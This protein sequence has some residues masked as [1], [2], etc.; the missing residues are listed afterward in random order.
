MQPT[1]KTPSKPRR[2]A[3]LGDFFGAA[4]AAPKLAPGETPI[5][6]YQHEH[7]PVVNRK[8]EIMLKKLNA[9]ES[10]RLCHDGDFLKMKITQAKVQ[11]FKQY[12]VILVYYNA[13]ISSINLALTFLFV[14]LFQEHVAAKSSDVT[15]PT[16]SGIYANPLR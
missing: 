15:R 9:S 4:P 14:C 1:K 7:D 5:N 13:A 12:K 8:I 16:Q 10:R 11:L 3:E 2:F 6:P